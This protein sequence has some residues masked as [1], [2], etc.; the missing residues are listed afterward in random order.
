MGINGTRK[1]V[2][3]NFRNLG[4]RDPKESQKSETGYDPGETRLDLGVIGQGGLICLIGA[5]NEGKSNVLEG[6][7]KLGEDSINASDKPHFRDMGG[8]DPEVWV[9]YDFF[10]NGDQAKAF[11]YTR[12]ALPVE[13]QKIFVISICPE[14]NNTE[15]RLSN[16][17]I[18]EAIHG[19]MW[20]IFDFRSDNTI[21]LN[22]GTNRVLF[23]KLC[24]EDSG[25]TL[26]CFN[27]AVYNSNDEEFGSMQD[28]E[29]YLSLGSEEGDSPDAYGNASWLVEYL[30]KHRN[31]LFNS[32]IPKDK[33]VSFPK[34]FFYK[35]E[36]LKHQDLRTTYEELDKSA[37]FV[38][39]FKVLKNEDIDMDIDYVRLFYR[40]YR[41]SHDRED[42]QEPEERI[43]TLLKT[44]ISECFNTMFQYV[45]TEN[46]AIEAIKYT[47]SVEL[48]SGHVSFIMRKDNDIIELDRQSAGFQKFFHF[49]FNFLY[50][51]GIG[52]G[53]IVLIDEP[54]NSLS[55]PAQRE[56]RSLLRDFGSGWGITFIVS[57]HSPFM[58]DMDHLDEVRMV[59]KNTGDGTKGSWIDNNFSVLRNKKDK[60]DKKIKPLE[61][62]T[63]QKIFDALGISKLNLK[64]DRVIFVEGVMD[65]NIFGAYQKIYRENKTQ[66]TFLPIGGLNKSDDLNFSKAQQNKIDNLCSFAQQIGIDRP[67]L[68]ADYDKAGRA[69]QKGVTGNP[70]FPVDVITLKDAFMDGENP[71][72]EFG[73]LCNRKD[74]QIRDPF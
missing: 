33:N 45:K 66:F 1:I 31:K 15:L 39:L 22:N 3:E 6:I 25:K 46:E 23:C 68:L 58:L 61:N 69:V 65:Y 38:S 30:K 34:I 47:F 17:G 62:M 64:D 40:Q 63:L 10:N 5:N 51:G 37:F 27:T 21:L 18:L 14:D 55:I 53:D 24:E 8:R 12:R 54:E 70:N 59:V 72:A 74:N 13:M 32:K 71:K 29:I 36:A 9:Q 16:I 42:L 19:R 49:F 48:D 26:V 35:E 52:K 7:A 4:V 73:E 57:T 43:N 56:I 67:L 44:T 50:K 28:I 2:F 60:N 41:Q 11:S 20:T